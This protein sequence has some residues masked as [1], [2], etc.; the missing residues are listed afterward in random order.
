MFFK[1][2]KISIYLFSLAAICIFSNNVNGKNH[3]YDDD[4]QYEVCG[5][6]NKDGYLKSGKNIQNEDLSCIYRDV[7]LDR[8]QDKINLDELINVDFDELRV[9]KKVLNFD[10]IAKKRNLDD[11]NSAEN[12]HNGD[13]N[14]DTSSTYH[15]GDD[16]NDVSSSSRHKNIHD[17]GDGNNESGSSEHKNI[18][19]DDGEI[20]SGQYSS[21]S[22]NIESRDVDEKDVS[23]KQGISSEEFSANESN[24]GSLENVTD[25]KPTTDEIG[26]DDDTYDDE[27]IIDYIETDIVSTSSSQ[28]YENSSDHFSGDSEN[29]EIFEEQIPIHK[30]E[31]SSESDIGG[32]DEDSDDDQSI[33]TYSDCDESSVDT[34]SCDSDIDL[35][36]SDEDNNTDSDG[37]INNSSEDII[38]ENSS[39]SNSDDDW[40]CE[41]SSEIFNFDDNDKANTD[42]IVSGDNVHEESECDQDEE[43][44]NTE[45]EVSEITIVDGDG[46]DNGERKKKKCRKIRSHIED[47]D[48]EHVSDLDVDEQQD[49][50]NRF[51]HAPDNERIKT[52]TISRFEEGNSESYID[53]DNSGNDD[54]DDDCGSEN[55]IEDERSVSSALSLEYMIGDNDESRQVNNEN[56]GVLSHDARNTRSFGE[57]GSKGY[58]SIV[59]GQ[60]GDFD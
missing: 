29:V 1:N 34:T 43:I 21:Y 33:K 36:I 6:V 18:H 44:T 17:E 30:D 27:K 13:R 53:S 5:D 50:E 48:G 24:S 3:R 7:K 23:N 25:E 39:H 8:D 58:F 46:N 52:G 26:K 19:D 49:S 60:N 45:N 9:Q 41:S 15:D 55:W 28:E 11:T 22:N 4:S 59:H 51:R 56:S 54:D 40:D 47:F 14:G 32:D 35:I 12:N 57:T 31:D 16:S 37:V 10:K 38:Y 42:D 20:N 2:R